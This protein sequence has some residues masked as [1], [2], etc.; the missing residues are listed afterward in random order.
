MNE[1]YRKIVSDC[2]SK[3]D[4]LDILNHRYIIILSNGVK[5]LIKD[6]KELKEYIKSNKAEVIEVIELVNKTD[7][8][9]DYED[10]NKYRVI[11]N[12]LKD[13]SWYCEYVD[14]QFVQLVIASNIN[15]AIQKAIEETKSYY[16]YDKDVRYKPIK[17][18]QFNLINKEWKVVSFKWTE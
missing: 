5:G 12:A 4:E 1:T 14:K 10:E 9:L 17:V 11:V 2:Y 3:L 8:Y 16:D 15:E 18:E 7:R 13:D 6:R